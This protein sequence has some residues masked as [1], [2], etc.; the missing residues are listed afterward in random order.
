M[1][2]DDKIM[3]FILVLVMCVVAIIWIDAKYNTAEVRHAMEAS[4]GEEMK[5]QGH[6]R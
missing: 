6:G 2:N 1:R 4:Y 3:G 5:P